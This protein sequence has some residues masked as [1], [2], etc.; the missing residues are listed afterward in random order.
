M[1]R[2]QT[3]EKL[4]SSKL[5]KFLFFGGT[6]AAVNVALMIVFVDILGWNT[7]LLRNA[8]NVVSTELSLLYSFVAYRFFVWT[9]TKAAFESSMGRQL[10]NYHFSAGSAIVARW[11]VLFPV[12][13]SLGVHYAVNTILGAG[14]SC[15][16]NYVLSNRY[17]FK[18]SNP[19]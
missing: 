2:K 17:V 5:L 11:L 19:T 15:V 14:L 7:A 16:L 10:L 13:D 4:F 18:A 3:I 6:A 9:G 8:G 1:G 12:M